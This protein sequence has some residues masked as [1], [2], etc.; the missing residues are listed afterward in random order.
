M[1]MVNML[2]SGSKATMEKK[3]IQL[4]LTQRYKY[5]MENRVKNIREEK[6]LRKDDTT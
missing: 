6:K 3:K 5:Q 4:G 1:T 2:G